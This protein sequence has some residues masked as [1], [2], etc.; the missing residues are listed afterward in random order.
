[1]GN[2]FHLTRQGRLL[3]LVVGAAILAIIILAIISGAIEKWLWMQQLSYTGIF[4]TLLS[5]KWQMFSLAFVIVFLYLWINLRLANR[6]PVSREGNSAG[7]PE[8]LAK[9]GIQVSPDGLKRAIVAVSA[10]VAF[11]FALM[12]YAQ[13]DM[14]LRFHYGGSF[15]LP[16]PLFRVDLGYYLFRLPFYELLQNSLTVLKET[17]P[18]H[19]L[20]LWPYRCHARLPLLQLDPNLHQRQRLFQHRL[21]LFNQ[22]LI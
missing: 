18:E 20:N 11:F 1:M 21:L 7:L 2:Q 6:G 10:V 16:D 12:F 19:L 13:W 4:W 9:S 5:V 3:T 15:G 8:I 17:N 14:Y 22:P